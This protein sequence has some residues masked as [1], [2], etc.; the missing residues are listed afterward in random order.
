VI[1]YNSRGGE[2]E[3]YTLRAYMVISGV[4]LVIVKEILGHLSI[5]MT[6]R[7]VHPTPENKRRAVNVLAAIFNQKKDEKETG[8][9]GIYA[10]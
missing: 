2:G 1:I 10:N 5:K 7:Y 6:M 3:F 8:K 4:S 9:H